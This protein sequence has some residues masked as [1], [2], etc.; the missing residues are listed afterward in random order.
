MDNDGDDHWLYRF[1]L[2]FRD[3]SV[4]LGGIKIM[5]KKSCYDITTFGEMLIDFTWQG[6][7]EEGQA[8][9]AQ[10]PGGAPA[11]VAVAAAKLGAC[12]AFLGKAG[13]DMHGE[14]L[15]EVLR[16]EN[17]ETDGMLLDERFFTTLAFV[18]TEENGSMISYDPNYRASLWKN[19]E[20]A[21]EQMRSLIP[22][23]DIMKISDEETELLTGKEKPEMENEITPH[24]EAK[25]NPRRSVGSV[26]IMTMP[27]HWDA[28]TRQS[29]ANIIGKMP[30]L[31]GKCRKP[32]RYTL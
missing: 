28:N 11:N 9:F 22:Y 10:N 12:T 21:K 4:C 24:K 8:V 23:V 14:F 6:V 17:V 29:V 5:T 3:Q 31:Q 2:C 7:N 30:L 16:K 1:D 19:E 26:P 15:K 18:K 13:K 27:Q 25:L 32:Y 20:T